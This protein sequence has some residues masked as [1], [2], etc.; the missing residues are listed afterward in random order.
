MLCLDDAAYDRLVELNPEQLVPIRLGDFEANDDALR[1]AKGNR[2]LVEYY[3]TCTPSLPL[4]VLRQR[5][6]LSAVFYVDSDF[7]FFADD[8][9]LREELSQGSVLI[10]EH[11]YP[12]Q[13]RSHERFGKFNVGVL[14]FRNNAEG[15]SCLEDWRA[16]CLEWCHDR[17]EDGKFADQKYLDAW[18]H[19]YRG[20]V[21]S[22]HPGINLAPWNKGNY[23]LSEVKGRPCVDGFPVVCFHFHGVKFAGGKLIQP[24]AMDY[25]TKLDASW[26]NWIYRPY[27]ERLIAAEKQYSADASGDIRY[28]GSASAFDAL[29]RQEPTQLYWSFGNGFLQVPTVLLK[30]LSMMRRFAGS[31]LRLLRR[32]VP[33]LHHAP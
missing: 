30:S 21:V 16:Q 18:P 11:R 14:G 25:G 4:F 32:L 15:R 20:V 12:S 27:L 24:Q 10:V 2:S 13:W 1:T 23:R 22:S 31:G 28:R 8:Q 3:F 19:L 5:P 7:F 6:E 33:F 9:S 29:T 26:F 17:V